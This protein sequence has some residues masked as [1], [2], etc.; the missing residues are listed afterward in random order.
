MKV[1]RLE[2]GFMKRWWIGLVMV[3]LSACAGL[4]GGQGEAVGQGGVGEGPARKEAPV[5]APTE[6]PTEVAVALEDYGPAPELSNEV[7]LN[8][9]KPL[10]MA[11]L[12]GKVVLV[13]MWT[14]G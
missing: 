6:A 4:R 13:D 8:T 9:D 3:A 5:E 2:G 1:G 11:D 12:T 14:F 7:W 10:R